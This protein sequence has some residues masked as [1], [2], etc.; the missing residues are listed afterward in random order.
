LSDQII[1]VKEARK[2]LG[3]EAKSMSDEEIEKVINDLDAIAK[4]YFEGVRNGTIKIPPKEERA[5][6]SK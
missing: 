4:H 6:G 3:K 2:I 5:N 1:S